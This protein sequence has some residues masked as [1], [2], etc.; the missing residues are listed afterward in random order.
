MVMNL[1]G[2]HNYNQNVIRKHLYH[3]FKNGKLTPFPSKQYTEIS[4]SANFKVEIHCEKQVSKSLKTYCACF[5]FVTLR[6]RTGTKFGVFG[7]LLY[8]AGINFC[9]FKILVMLFL[10]ITKK[11]RTSNKF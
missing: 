1:R 4:A 3:C 7:G 6:L 10:L 2:S 11:I 5:G 9:V 8:L